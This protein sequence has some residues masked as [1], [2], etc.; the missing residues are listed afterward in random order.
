MDSPSRRDML[1]GL[2]LIASGLLAGCQSRRGASVPGPIWPD[3]AGVPAAPR[4]TPPA[5]PSPGLPPKIIAAPAPSGVVPRSAW[6]SSGA[7]ASRAHPMNGISRITVHHSAIAS[8]GL[9]TQADVARMLSS[10]RSEHLSR[11]DPKT[12]KAWADIGYHFMIDPQGRVWEG[13]PLSLQGAHV[14]DTNEHNLGILM[15]GHFD[16]ERPSSAALSTLDGFV[17]YQMRSYGVPISRV[18]THQELRPSACPGRNL[19]KYMLDTRSRSGRL[20]RG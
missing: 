7:V 8:G 10:I 4:P 13:R 14:A 18:Y 5:A 20:A 16:R 11:R 1:G 9:R 15:L 19:Q 12:G 17:A 6:T 2:L 3:E